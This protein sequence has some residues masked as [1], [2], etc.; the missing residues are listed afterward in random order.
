M[1]GKLMCKQLSTVRTRERTS[2]LSTTRSK[3]P[4]L[5]STEQED[6]KP[7]PGLESSMSPVASESQG[8]LAGVNVF[9]EIKRPHGVPKGGWTVPLEEIDV[10]TGG[11]LRQELLDEEALWKGEKIV[12][13]H[14]RPDE[15]YP[16]PV[17]EGVQL[18]FT[19]IMREAGRQQ[20]DWEGMIEGLK[21]FYARTPTARESKLKLRATLV[22]KTSEI[23]DLG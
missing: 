21:T 14:V 23:V 12:R 13:V 5:D 4:V 15:R 7:H 9:L 16:G 11:R 10:F 18:E 19:C 17:V 1:E 20:T 3:T 6:A 8:P 22:V 2:A